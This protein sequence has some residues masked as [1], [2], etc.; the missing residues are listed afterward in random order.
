MSLPNNAKPGSDRACW[1]KIS[2]FRLRT[3]KTFKK[4]NIPHRRALRERVYHTA[5][6]VAPAWCRDRRSRSAR[7]WAS[8]LLEIQNLED[9]NIKYFKLITRT[10]QSATRWNTGRWCDSGSEKN[11]LMNFKNINKKS[12]IDHLKTLGWVARVH[13]MIPIV[14]AATEKYFCFE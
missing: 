13:T 12:I 9:W 8:L 2:K 11:R 1:E 6:R 3:K 5:S 14:T 10:N 7:R 4:I